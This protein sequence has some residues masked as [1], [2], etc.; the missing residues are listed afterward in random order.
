MSRLF[1]DVSVAEPCTQVWAEMT[2]SNNKR[3]CAACERSVHNLEA[4][5]ARQ[6]E[7][8]LVETNGNL[9]G[10]VRTLPDG[11]VAHH[12]LTPARSGI[13]FLALS[14]FIGSAKVASA[15]TQATQQGPLLNS[16]GALDATVAGTITD[17]TGALVV[18]AR[19]FAVLGSMQVASTITD[20]RGDYRLALPIGSYV[21][22]VAAEGFHA[23][24]LPVQVDVN[25][26][27]QDVA[28]RPTATDSITVTSLPAD[29]TST[30]VGALASNIKFGRW[31]K[32]A[33]YRLRHPV[34]YTRY[35]LRPR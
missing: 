6:I 21:L 14:A 11:S 20:E 23:A 35:L 8:L 2:G 24:D 18:G 25:P 22:K 29:Y 7:A 16:Q 26:V 1:F 27:S 3:Y 33:G 12:A 5:T 15:Q 32:R 34:A 4:L 28:M 10:R 30:T 13:A 17:Q 31:Y 19:I 9:C